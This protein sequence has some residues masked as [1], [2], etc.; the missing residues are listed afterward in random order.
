MGWP[1]PE[2][3]HLLSL[4]DNHLPVEGISDNTAKDKLRVCGILTSARHDA[5]LFYCGRRQP[6]PAMA[7]REGKGRRRRGRRPRLFGQHD[8]GRG[9]MPVF[10]RRAFFAFHTSGN[11]TVRCGIPRNGSHEKRSNVWRNQ[12]LAKEMAKPHRPPPPTFPSSS[13]TSPG[14]VSVP[15]FILYTRS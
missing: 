15:A 10:A 7:M 14:C 5:G 12:L 4:D 3:D 2:G 13:C 1:T 9:R 11:V 8:A 6:P